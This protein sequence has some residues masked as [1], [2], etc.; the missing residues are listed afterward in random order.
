MKPLK[1]QAI[2]HPG[3]KAGVENK[4]LR[5]TY[6]LLS[7]TLLFSTLTAGIAVAA[8]VPHPGLLITLAGYFGLLFLTNKFRNSIYGVVC[9]FALTGFMGLTLG[10]IISSYWAMAPQ[11]VMQALGAT[12]V[13]FIGLS[14]YAAT[15]KRD[16]SFMAS[17]LFAGILVGFCAGLGAILFQLPALSLVV[18]TLFVLLMSGMILFETQQIVR[19]GETNYIMATVALFVTIFNLFTSLLHLLGFAQGE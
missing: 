10:P 5:N 11:V 7:M 12:S 4:V 3:V 13:I 18:S 6:L 17:F 8:N 15:T 16:F 19:G 2:Y 9:V 14:A 1:A